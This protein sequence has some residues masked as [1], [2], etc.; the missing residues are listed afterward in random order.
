M[1]QHLPDFLSFL[2]FPLSLGLFAGLHHPVVLVVLFVSCGITD[3]LDGFLARRWH[4]T[5]ARGARLDSVADTVFYLIVVTVT[6]LAIDFN[7]LFVVV[8]AIVAA[9]KLFNIGLTRVKFACWGGIHTL[10]N[11]TAGLVF[12]FVWPICAVLG[13]MPDGA[14]LACGV[15]ALLAAVEELALLIGQST[16]DPDTKGIWYPSD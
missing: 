14:A 12:F 4:S 3:V 15:I 16:Y 10:A 11:K 9:V 1:K 13:R 8:I 7:D 2:R 6:L 5:S